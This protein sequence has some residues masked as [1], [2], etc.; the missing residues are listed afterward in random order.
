[1]VA[2]ILIWILLITSWVAS[3]S[4]TQLFDT[5]IAGRWVYCQVDRG[6]VVAGVTKFPSV[7]FRWVRPHLF[8]SPAPR[9]G[10]FADADTRLTHIGSFTFGVLPMQSKVGNGLYQSFSHHLV[11]FPGLAAVML[12]TI[13]LIPTGFMAFRVRRRF[14]AG[15]C[16]TCGYDLRATPERCPECGHIA[17]ESRE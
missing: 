10:L 1:L 14:Q 11:G 16:P 3:Y 2:G 7:H 4:S 15:L 12:W 9:S 17:I 6:H 13:V 8:L 5:D